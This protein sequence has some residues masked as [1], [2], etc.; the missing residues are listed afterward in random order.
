MRSHTLTIS[1]F[2][3]LLNA[4]VWAAMNR[5]H[6]EVP[7]TG[8]V[9]GV[10][11][12]PYR[13][14]QDPFAERF[15]SREE[16][17][18]DLRF[19][20]DKVKKVRT[21]SSLDGI[22]Q[23]PELAA[24]YG[25][26]VT[27]GAWLDTRR[28]RNEREIAGLIRNAK[29]HRNIDRVIV[30]NEAL[31]RGDFTVKELGAYL[32][33]VR[34]AIKQPVS[35]AE[36]WHVWIKNP[37][38]A[39]H[40]DFIAI[41]ILPYW[42]GVPAEQAMQFLKE[43]YEEVRKA[44]P[45]KPVLI[46]ET[47]WP[48]GG[49]REQW[50]R[51]SL[52]NEAKFLRQFFNFAAANQVDYFVMEAFDQPWK[53]RIE[54]EV[55]A[56]WGMFD[57]ERR[58]KFPMTG[59]VV[60]NP[61]WTAQLALATFLALIPML[62]FL[63]KWKEVR[64]SGHV[65]YALIVQAAA[66]LVA[67]TVFVPVTQGLGLAGQI[68]WGVLLPAQLALLIVMLI[69]SFEFTELRFANRLKR[70]FPSLHLMRHDAAPKVSLHVAICKE[71]PEIV[72]QTLNSLAALDYPN[73]EVIVIDNNTPDEN[74]WRP[75]AE[76]CAKLGE[77]FRFYSLGKWPGFKAGALN[78]ALKETAPDAQ[79]VGVID[80]DYVVRPDWL[81]A[82]VHYFSQPAVGFVQAP[83][84]NRDWEGSTFHEM[85]N[86]EYAG[87]FHL[88]MVHRNERD[89]II[90]H[91]TM[92]LIRKAPLVELGGWSEWCICE[93]SELGLRLMK[94]G[95]ESVYINEVFGR[96]LTPHTFA[97][98]KSQ[99]FRW[100]YGAAQILKAHWRSLLPWAKD[101]RLTLA[102]RFHFVGGW[103]PWFADG[104]HLVF[105][106]AALA[107]TLGLLLLPQHFDFPLVAFLLPTLAMFA[108]KVFHTLA[109][110]RS[111]VPCSRRQRWLAAVAG[112]SLTHVIA[113]GVFQGLFTRNAPF[114][115]TPKA[116]DKPALLRGLAMAREEAHM[117]LGLWVA[118]LGLG[119]TY[120][121]SNEDALL[122]Q[123]VLMV[124][125]LP[126]L[127]AVYTAV[128]NVLPAARQHSTRPATQPVLAGE[129]AAGPDLPPRRAA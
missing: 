27:A 8:P 80:S 54:E 90:Q 32:Q 67:W 72:I 104:L 92:T 111:H 43:R 78:F 79:I 96:G 42:E 118:A 68:A 95:Y 28:E 47:G 14:G 75:V 97:G 53:V 44:F 48:S 33:R 2:V 46:A 59:P 71:P 107:W 35:T 5:P 15:P 23:V 119:A 16:I 57:V 18:Q 77:R 129:A 49:D 45:G 26:T 81:R 9:T 37:E 41:H 12:S 74:L 100:V 110:Y 66:S 50:S 116:E 65:F 62:W 19:L 38:L 101:S 125:S 17:D 22:E 84:D 91:G 93:D 34:K 58:A 127:A 10:S 73:F 102:Q 52:V 85:L 87:F 31:L 60:E 11:F 30:G 126:Y 105:S 109:L 99:R 106:L 89:A 13:A 117:M 7:W 124:Q 6:D 88:G 82:T 40:V 21:Y 83:Q 122:W 1:L 25:L 20:A 128:V 115:R 70:R 63:A 94:Q 98:Y 39:K 55:G 4:L 120:G 121:S 24:R 112:M 103:L 64:A 61:W 76:H 86:W 3:L 113:R 56:H 114:L 51:P 123:I 69:N 108:F 29:Q 36:P